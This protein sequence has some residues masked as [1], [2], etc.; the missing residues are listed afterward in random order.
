MFSASYLRIYSVEF[1]HESK[2]ANWVYYDYIYVLLLKFDEYEKRKQ[3][4]DDLL[5]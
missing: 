5:S 2:K 3:A 4:K 1:H